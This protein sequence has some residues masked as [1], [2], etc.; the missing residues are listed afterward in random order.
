MNISKIY[1][2]LISGL[3]IMSQPIINAADTPRLVIP[4]LTAAPK[5]DGSLQDAVWNEAAQIGNFHGVKNGVNM[6]PGTEKT[7]LK[8]GYTDAG[9]FIGCHMNDSA[10]LPVNQMRHEFICRCNDGY[11]HHQRDDSLSVL[12]IP[13]DAQHFDI[14]K[15]VFFAM[16]GR[17]YSA[18]KDSPCYNNYFKYRKSWP[19]PKI[20]MKAKITKLGYWNLEV[21]IPFKSLKLSTPTP[22]T[23]WLMNFT[24]FIPRLTERVH[25]VAGSG[26]IDKIPESK[27]PLTA[28]DYGE[29]IFG[30]TNSTV[31]QV[32][33]FTNS[34][35][36]RRKLL[37]D[38]LSHANGS[39]LWKLELKSPQGKIV[40][41]HGEQTLKPGVNRCQVP[42]SVTSEGKQFAYC[43]TLTADKKIIYCSG[44]HRQQN[45]AAKAILQLTSNAPVTVYWNGKL[46]AENS[47]SLGNRS[48]PLL[49]AANVIALQSPNPAQL[50]VTVSSKG[51]SIPLDRSWKYATQVPEDWQKIDFDD[52]NWQALPIK[53]GRINLPGN[54]KIFLR[55]TILNQTTAIFPKFKNNI[56]EITAGGTDVIIWTGQGVPGWNL[57]RPLKDFKLFFDLPQGLTLVGVGNV[58][59]VLINGKKRVVRGRR[60]EFSLARG[61]SFVHDKQKLQRYI[62]TLKKPV[63]ISSKLYV[64]TADFTCM[65]LRFGVKAAANLQPGTLL[66]IYIASQAF[67]GNFSEFP[68]KLNC[69]ILPKLQGRYPKRLNFVI[70]EPRYLNLLDSPAIETAYIK[71]LKQAGI[72]NLFAAITDT[73]PK[74]LHINQLFF[75]NFWNNLAPRGEH[76][77]SAV[78]LRQ[79]MAEHPDAVAVTADGK[80][81]FT[82]C[83][84]YLAHNRN[85]I[86][87]AVEK[88]FAAMLKRSPSL[89]TIFWDFEFPMWAQRGTYTGFSKFGIATFKQQYHIK[90]ALTPQIIKQ[91]YQLEWREFMEGNFAAICRRLAAICHKHHIRFIT[92]TGYEPHAS[93]VCG[94]SLAKNNPFVDLAF[95][96]YGRELA[97]LRLTQKAVGKKLNC[98]ILVS[99]SIMASAPTVAT[100]VQRTLDSRNGFHLWLE[101]GMDGHGLSNIAKASQPLVEYENLIID[102]KATA[103][104]KVKG[105]PADD[106]Y[107]F[108]ANNEI[109]V[110]VVNT[111]ALAKTV[112][113][114][115]PKAWQKQPLREFYSKQAF[116]GPGISCKIAPFQAVF[117][118][119]KKSK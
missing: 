33:R 111:S 99:R 77:L 71:T 101:G 34:D 63:T 64:K 41:C 18:I 35:F 21:F 59:R 72:N 73:I 42:L 50:S 115:L 44:W 20:F 32:S 60:L 97:M 56:W 12:L 110:A 9:I 78:G 48:L 88:G 117:L 66:P 40:S 27:A 37:C 89:N 79:F 114:S 105:L 24:R 98:G 70:M 86:W 45:E 25:W 8:I 15:S 100:L 112:S 17:G 28:G 46:L 1:C 36:K 83:P 65:G 38:I 76:G 26:A 7:S 67:N 49:N 106:C 3:I 85:N 5:I 84:V 29:I 107:C 31:A 13:T 23:E 2:G 10:L 108:T 16:N 51:F 93:E 80:K 53:N 75:F 118:Y 96:G 61:K 58:K 119:G 116:K 94:F 95:C 102:G 74:E 39:C 82:P 92:W 6:T 90:Q 47:K 43:L 30:T 54:G 55:K 91:H 109:L 104:P 87:A 11:L 103:L 69:K 22:G 68:V 4:K 81:G 57:N 113:F 52:S 14:T 62:I 19:R